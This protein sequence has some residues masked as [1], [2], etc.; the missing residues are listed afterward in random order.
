M[1]LWNIPLEEYQ[2]VQKLF[3]G[4]RQTQMRRR[5]GVLHQAGFNEN[6]RALLFSTWRKGQMLFISQHKNVNL[7][8]QAT[9]ERSKNLHRFYDIPSNRLSLVI[10]Y[11][12]QTSRVSH[13]ESDQTHRM[14]SRVWSWNSHCD[15]TLTAFLLMNVW[16][17]L[18]KTRCLS[19]T[20]ALA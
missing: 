11:D 5:N 8:V 16:N 14:T 15:L 9:N 12:L 2:D 7:D 17:I 10:L 20:H 18:M 19:N 4:K 6:R 13:R 1:L 3:R